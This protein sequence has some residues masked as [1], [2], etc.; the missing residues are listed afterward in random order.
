M[1]RCLLCNLNWENHQLKA[2]HFFYFL[3]Y[4]GPEWNPVII[5]SL[6]EYN[7][8]LKGS[9]GYDYGVY[10]YWANAFAWINGSTNKPAGS[11]VTFN[12]YISNN[13]GNFSQNFQ[14]EY[15]HFCWLCQLSDRLAVF[16]LFQGEFYYF[17]ISKGIPFSHALQCSNKWLD[18]L[19]WPN[20]YA[21]HLHFLWFRP[22]ITFDHCLWDTCDKQD[23]GYYSESF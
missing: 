1:F 21:L 8:V 23:N 4:L 7:N 2:F 14:C 19:C 5:K 13:T 22:Q 6:Q 17:V 15:I 9:S 3:G 20:L 16:V 10:F 12:N 18:I 11:T